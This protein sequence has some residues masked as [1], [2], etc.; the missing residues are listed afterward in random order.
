MEKKNLCIIQARFGSSRLPGKVL[1]EVEGVALLEYE[2]KR[3]K[4]AKKIDK[5][6]VATTDKKADNRI[7]KLCKKI[8][9]D[10][11]RGSEEDVLDRYYQCSLRYP[12]FGNIVRITGDCPLIDPVVID[13]VISFFIKNKLDYASNIEKETFPDGMDVEIFRREVLNE[14][15]QMAKL[16]SQREH[17]TLYIRNARKYRKGNLSSEHDFSHFRLTVDQRED[18]E[19]IKFLIENSNVYDG[20]MEYVSL[21]TK[22]P[23]IMMK[24]IKIKRNMGLAK[25]LKDEEARNK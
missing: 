3:V 18:Y 21:L 25:S 22:N 2:I 23:E 4:Q 1:L 14:V 10:C 9:I 16:A 12:K 6:V 8:Q 20:Y 5:I 13:R 7:E 15:A 11:F 19:V 24:N 17:V